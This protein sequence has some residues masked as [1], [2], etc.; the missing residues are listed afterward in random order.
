M[1]IY[2]GDTTPDSTAETTAGIIG[3]HEWIGDGW[4][5]LRSPPR[6]VHRPG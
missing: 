6:F 4:E 3:V 1:A 2:L 5:A